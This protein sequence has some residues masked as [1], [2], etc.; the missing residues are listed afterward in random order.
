[1]IGVYHQNRDTIYI[2][3][4]VSAE[5]PADQKPSASRDLYSPHPS[6]RRSSAVL[7]LDPTGAPSHTNI[8]GL[9]FMPTYPLRQVLN[10]PLKVKSEPDFLSLCCGSNVIIC[11]IIFVKEVKLLSAFDLIGSNGHNIRSHCHAVCQVVCICFQQL[12][13]GKCA[14]C[15]HA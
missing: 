15:R 6:P 8:L 4:S 12:Q 7:L 9:R 2:K 5:Y 1:M 10:M 13:L 14:I 11:L 3:F